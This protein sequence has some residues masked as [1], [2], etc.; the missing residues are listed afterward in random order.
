LFSQQAK[1]WTALR[2]WGMTGFDRSGAIKH[3]VARRA[4]GRM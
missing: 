2:N 1:T 4:M 3:W